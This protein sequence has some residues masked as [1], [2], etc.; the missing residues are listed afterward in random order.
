VAVA[1]AVIAAF[2]CAAFL[3]PALVSRG[4]VG[5]VV[6]LVLYVVLVAVVRPRGLTASWSY[7]RELR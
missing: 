6:G 3:P 4:I 2:T 1:A 7:L 5:A